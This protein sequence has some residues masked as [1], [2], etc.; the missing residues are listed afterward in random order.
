[1]SRIP[2]KT[3][4]KRIPKWSHTE[5]RVRE[6]P[7]CG[8]INLPTIER[9]D[10][11]PVAFCNVCKCWYVERVP[12]D[13]D[14]LKFYDSYYSK[15]RPANFG[16]SL[17]LN[18]IHDAA[19]DVERNWEIQQLTRVCGDVSGKKLLDVGCGLGWFLLRAKLV[20]FTV[21][22]CDISADACGFIE[23]HLGIPVHKSELSTCLKF[24]NSIDVVVMRD[25]IE[26]STNPLSEIEAVS[27]MLSAGGR[28]LLLT[29][30]GSEASSCADT[31]NGWIGFRVD[32]E[33]FQYISPDTIGFLCNKYGFV[34][35]RLATYGF[36]NLKGLENL[37]VGRLK[38]IEY[39]FYIAKQ[40]PGL[41]RTIRI[42]RN[43]FQRV[44]FTPLDSRLGS[45]H[46]FAILR[47]L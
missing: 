32:L 27:K 9:P 36:P 29:P 3:Y 6:C 24:M 16:K 42:V 21:T 26:H 11:L 38:A 15:H 33:H 47:K 4:D 13:N 44:F 34:V 10:F 46:L 28:L 31:E 5:L 43:T 40:I 14:V 39:I 1:M 35:E 12:C 7:F 20:G 2:L 25:F 17:A 23:Q 8:Q 30:N 37:P 19:L 22:G 45:Y 41:Q 18:M